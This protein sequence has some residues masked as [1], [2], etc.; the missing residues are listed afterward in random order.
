L[1]NNFYQ[2]HVRKSKSRKESDLS[3]QC[4][5]HVLQ[6]VF[7]SMCGWQMWAERTENCHS[8]Q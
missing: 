4:V 6:S 8:N 7:I 1:N 5:L 3:R 2:N